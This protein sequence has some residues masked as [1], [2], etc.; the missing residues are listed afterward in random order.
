MLIAAFRPPCGPYLDR[1]GRARG[2]Q[3]FRASKAR[4]RSQIHNTSRGAGEEVRSFDR[5]GRKH[6]TGTG[7]EMQ[8]G[9]VDADV[10]RWVCRGVG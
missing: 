1:G 8:T 6:K 3:S 2:E 10:E 9:R 5:V 4:V 7:R